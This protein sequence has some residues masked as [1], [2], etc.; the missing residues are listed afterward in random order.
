M[1]KFSKEISTPIC[2]MNTS[3]T[4]QRFL[5]T[6]RGKH[7]FLNWLIISLLHKALTRPNNTK[8]HNK[9]HDKLKISSVDVSQLLFDHHFRIQYNPRLLI[10]LHLWKR[11]WRPKYQSNCLTYN[12]VFRKPWPMISCSTL[13]THTPLFSWSSAQRKIFCVC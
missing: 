4:Q 13:T 12:W 5:I 10:I 8:T 11:K 2:S 9:L 6:R 1:P 3:L 7:R